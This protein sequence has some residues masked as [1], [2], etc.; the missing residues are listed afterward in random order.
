MKIQKA[1]ERST[2]SQQGNINYKEDPYGN[3]RTE[4]TKKQIKMMWISTTA[5][6]R[7]QSK[8]SVNQKTE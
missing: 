4:N 3:I 5:E 2:K 7:A 6:W 8:K 1:K